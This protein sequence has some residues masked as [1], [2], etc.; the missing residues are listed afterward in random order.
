[1]TIQIFVSYAH[2]DMEVDPVYKDS[3]MSQILENIMRELDCHDSRSPFKILIDKRGMIFGGDCI[4]EKISDAVNKCDIGLIL[5]TASYC[6]SEECTSELRQLLTAGKRLC[7]VEAEDVWSG[8]YENDLRVEFPKLDRI[9]RLPYWGKHNQMP[10]KY[11]WPLPNL[12]SKNHGKYQDALE[13]AA[14]SIK[15]IRLEIMADKQQNPISVLREL[16]Q[17]DVFIASPTADVKREAE[18]LEEAL[19]LDGYSVL[20]FDPG[21]YVSKNTDANEAVELAISKCD[22]AV[23]LF[24]AVPGGRMNDSELQSIPL[25]YDLIKSSGKTMFSWESS[26]FEHAE[27]GDNYREFLQTVQTHKS[28]YEDFEQYV[29]KQVAKKTKEVET[30][31]DSDAEPIVS[32]DFAEPDTVIADILMNA[33]T[34]HA[35]VMPLEFDLNCDRLEQAVSDSDGIVMVYGNCRAGQ[36]RTGAHFGIV[37]RFKNRNRSAIFDLAIGNSQESHAAYPRGPNVHIFDIDAEKLV[38]DQGTLSE[39]VRNIKENAARRYS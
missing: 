33:L 36:K 31:S 6:R 19:K 34:N 10:I 15:N 12:A 17:H 21:Q 35:S 30:L 27:I 11:G 1:M 7:I 39:F 3:R 38:V 37:Q 22:L 8:D 5:L 32:I 4:D 26:Q 25:Q 9:L 13:F 23:Q 24:G 20:K 29:L 28:S 16:D 2:A 18:R 14:N